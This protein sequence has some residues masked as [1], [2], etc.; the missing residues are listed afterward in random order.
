M[1]QHL[2][3]SDLLVLWVYSP[4]R[5]GMKLF[6]HWYAGVLF[7]KVIMFFEA[8]PFYISSNII[9]CIAV[10]K[11]LSYRGGWHSSRQ[12][13][14]RNLLTIGWIIALFTSAPQLWWYSVYNDANNKP[15]CVDAHFVFRTWSFGLLDNATFFNYTET[16]GTDWDFID[17]FSYIYHVFHLM[18]I[19]WAP[20]LLI[21]FCYGWLV[22]V[23]A[24]KPKYQI[25]MG[26]QGS[27]K[28]IAGKNDH[29]YL[30]Q[31]GI[32]KETRYTPA[33]ATRTKVIRTAAL[34]VILYVVCWIPY[35]LISLWSFWNS[36][37]SH[38][39]MLMFLHQLIVF[40]SVINPYIYGLSDLVQLCHV[41][42]DEIEDIM[43]Y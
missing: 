36:T 19:F 3:F 30:Q 12:K 43:I 4:C 7:C 23:I 26:R 20:L 37:G 2:N 13:R 29:Q 10:D 11:V 1:L 32:A 5:I 35:N 39:T 28:A 31:H 18:M 16:T 42:T 25:V 8:L 40:N 14:V 41:D 38:P 17:Q 6:Q 24:T 9:V 34:L 21:C 15:V 22:V 33:A 27:A